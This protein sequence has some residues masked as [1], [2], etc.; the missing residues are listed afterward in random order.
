LAEERLD[1]AALTAIEVAVPPRYAPM[2]DGPTP[3]PGRLNTIGSV[4]Y[5][6]ALAAY[7]PDDLLD[8][9]RAGRPSAP[10]LRAP[11]ERVR[12]VADPALAA[13]YPRAW[14]ARVTVTV[15][16]ARYTRTVEHAP[17]DPTRPLDWDAVETKALRVTRGLVSLDELAGLAT[18]CR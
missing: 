6:L 7:Y 9:A 5:G 15:G 14:P 17:G 2:I 10:A 13:V 3:A 12:V 16:D 4:H 11:M 1:P 18:Y 8:V